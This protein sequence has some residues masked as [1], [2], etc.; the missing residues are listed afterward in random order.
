MFQLSE[1]AGEIASGDQSNA[2]AVEPTWND[3]TVLNDRNFCELSWS[4][5]KPL[6]KAKP[7]ELKRQTYTQQDLDAR[8]TRDCK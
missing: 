8:L 1:D 5:E 6:L 7:C 4:P 2:T 3:A